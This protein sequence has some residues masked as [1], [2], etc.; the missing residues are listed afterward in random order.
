MA[1]EIDSID[2]QLSLKASMVSVEMLNKP[3]GMIPGE[4]NRV[5]STKVS[6]ALVIN[7]N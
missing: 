2:K 4:C 6:I 1:A 5:C 7:E 3:T